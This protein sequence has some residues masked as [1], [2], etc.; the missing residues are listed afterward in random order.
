[1]IPTGISQ[2]ENRDFE[3]A[4]DKV[5]KPAPKRAERG[6]RFFES[7]MPEYLTAWGTISPTKDISP[8]RLTAHPARSAVKIRNMILKRLTLSPNALA[9]SSPMEIISSLFEKK[10]RKIKEAEIIIMAGISF[11]NVTKEKSPILKSTVISEIVGLNDI[12]ESVKAPNKAF[13]A[14][15]VKITV[16]FL[17]PALRETM[18]KSKTA[19]KAPKNAIKESLYPPYM[20]KQAA[21]VTARPAPEF[22]PII[23]G[24][25]NLLESNDCSTAPETL[26]AAPTNS[27]ESVLGSLEYK[28]IISCGVVAPFTMEL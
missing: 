1:M 9:F 3:I 27:A 23:L 11:S 17:P 2:G 12:T 4:S 15:P 6:K 18:H 28:N 13:N 5:T 22:T 24:D 19:Q 7:V 20:P 10:N 26:N 16:L 14:T 21:I 25:A 8:A